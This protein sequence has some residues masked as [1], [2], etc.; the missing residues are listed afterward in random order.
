ME[1]S[2]AIEVASPIPGHA[3]SLGLAVGP[4]AGPLNLEL[5]EAAR[6][7][8]SQLGLNARLIGPGDELAEPGSILGVGFPGAFLGVL[9]A[10]SARSPARPLIAWVGE[11]LLPT[12]GPNGGPL[13]AAARSRA[14]DYLRYPL[15]PLKHAPLP[16]PIAR[17]RSSATGQRELARNTRDLAH[18]V[19]LVDRLVVTSRD[20][21]AILVGHG[22]E[23]DVV[24]YG[25]AAAVAGPITPPESGERDLAMVSLATL[26]PRVAWRRSILDQ[27]RQDEPRLTVANGIWGQDRYALLRRAR[28]VLNVQRVPGNFV[29]L[30][31]VL[32]LAAGAV[33]VGEP[34]T[35]PHPFVPG[36][37]FVSAPLDR[38][39]E[40]ARALLADEPRRRRMAAAGQ[41]MLLGELAMARCLSRV[42]TS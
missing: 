23:A 9:E 18:L 29:G 36:V 42:L 35:D 38:L 6:S 31:I 24:P 3:G 40:E 34:M 28:I 10:Q 17:I 41:E 21:A 32:A 22:I 33:M 7:A 19:A 16:G 1:P 5:V 25:Y 12:G 4:S 8:A 30:R 37:H 26:D 2:R 14:M 39:L 27:L 13:A 11:P 15:R 20:K